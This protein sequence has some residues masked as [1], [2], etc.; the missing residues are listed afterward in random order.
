M[1]K[2]MKLRGLIKFEDEKQAQQYKQDVLEERKE[3]EK[4]IEYVEDVEDKTGYFNCVR[5]VY[6]YKD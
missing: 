2:L 5:E 1:L 4:H 3:F 6:K